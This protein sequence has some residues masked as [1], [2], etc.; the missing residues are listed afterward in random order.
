MATTPSTGA[1]AARL[2]PFAFPSD[3]DL[4]FVLLMVSVVGSTMF[5]YSWFY[6][7]SPGATRETV[8]AAEC[9]KLYPPLGD[10]FGPNRVDTSESIRRATECQVP[11]WRQLAAWSLGG[12]LAVAAVAAI[13]YWLAP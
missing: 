13:A 7:L 5:I 2:N 3:T 12:V 10:L 9:L 8:A 6:N 1:P 11:Y 4:R